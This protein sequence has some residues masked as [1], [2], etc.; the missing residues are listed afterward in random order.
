VPTDVEAGPYGSL[1]VTT[2]PG[3]PGA[4]GGKPAGQ[5]W[6]VLPLTGAR[7]LVAEGLDNPT[8]LAVGDTGDVYVAELQANRISVV[9]AGSTT[10]E[11]V[12]DQT[13]PG[14][15]EWTED[16]LLASVDVLSG[17]SGVDPPRGE[18]VRLTP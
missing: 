9:R 11:R 16:G 7:Q 3:G 15:L 5:L 6:R 18:V 2:L 1:Y 4:R 13:F 17:T 14:D 12:A 8:G 10:P